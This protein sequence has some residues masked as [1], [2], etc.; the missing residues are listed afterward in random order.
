MNAMTL[1]KVIRPWTA[2]DDAL[3]LSGRVRDE[4]HYRQLLDFVESAFDKFGGDES[5]PVFG[6]VKIVADHI[7]EYENRVHPWDAAASPSELL[8]FL[9][10]QHA[11]RQSDLPEIG[12]QGVVSEILSGKRRINARQA[13]LLATRFGVEAGLF[14]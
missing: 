10:D 4:A 12:T 8:E 1:Q 3:G 6:L 14:L 7:R 2:V 9:M 11:L 13:K 5:H